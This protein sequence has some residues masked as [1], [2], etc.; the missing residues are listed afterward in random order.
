MIRTRD[1][2]LVNRLAAQQEQGGDYADFLAD[3]LHICLVE[4]ESG[5]LFAFRGPG[6]Y[7]VHV[8]FAAR[9]KSALRLGR[10]MLDLMRERFG[11]HLFWSLV[12]AESRR[13]IMFTRLMGWKSHGRVESPHGA[14]ELFSFGSCPCLHL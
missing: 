13:V 4:G 8:F 2:Q 9:G 5:A 1:A 6:I 11:A 12:P 7:E 3:P 14:R 10:A